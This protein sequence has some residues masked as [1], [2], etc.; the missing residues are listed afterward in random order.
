MEAWIQKELETSHFGD[1]RLSQRFMHIVDQLAQAP[2]TSIPEAMGNVAAVKATYRFWDNDKVN[3]VKILN[4]HRASTLRRIKAEK[5]VLVLHDTSEEN[6]TPH[7]QTQDL[8]YLDHPSQRGL[9]M[10]SSLAASVQGVPL[11]IL[12]QDFWRRD[13]QELGKKQQRHQRAVSQKESRKWLDSFADTHAV[14]EASTEVIHIA[15]READLYE[16]FTAPR[17]AHVHFL[18]RAS[19]NRRLAQGDGKL[20]EILESTKDLGPMKVEVSARKGQSTR[21]AVVHLRAAKVRLLAP[22]NKPSAVSE[23]S[24][25]AIEA[26]EPHPPKGVKALRWVLLTT[27]PLTSR[28]DVETYL[29]YYSLRW[30]I[31]RFFYTLKQGCQVEELQLQTAQRLK[32][33]I[34]TYSIIAWNLMFILYHSR[35]APHTSCESLFPKEQW[36]ILY[37]RIHQQTPPSEPPT[38]QQVVRW[39]AQLGGFLGRK[40]DGQPGIKTLWRG[41]RLFQELLTLSPLVTFQPPFVGK[42]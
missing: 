12:R 19:H 27:L 11:G 1:I 40:G 10:H 7:A 28:Q 22:K 5:R 25:W 32:N 39:I 38:L 20:F 36:Q 9:K 24:L 31:E 41:Y 18:I 21:E 6:Y 29:F 4:P 3:E 30:L 13:P 14:I 17:P 42:A 33:A 15:D 26:Y 34:N 35:Q 16:L 23:V 2:H 8:G 37:W